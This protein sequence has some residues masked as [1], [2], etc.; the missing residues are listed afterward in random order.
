MRVPGAPAHRSQEEAASSARPSCSDLVRPHPVPSTRLSQTPSGPELDCPEASVLSES[1]LV[2]GRSSFQLLSQIPRMSKNIP[3]PPVCM[4][5]QSIAFYSFLIPHQNLGVHSYCVP[6]LAILHLLGCFP[7]SLLISYH[8][9]CKN[10][11]ITHLLL[12]AFPD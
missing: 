12:E 10:G 11:C 2:P 1:F 8:C 9:L 5:G 7:S 4:G 3:S 6:A